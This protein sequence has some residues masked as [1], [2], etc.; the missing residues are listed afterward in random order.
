MIREN[1]DT[2]SVRATFPDSVSDLAC[3]S[4][5]GERSMH[6]YGNSP[7]TDTQPR[8]PSTQFR[9]RELLVFAIAHR[10]VERFCFVPEIGD[11]ADQQPLL[12]VPLRKIG[13]HA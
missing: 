9:N 13:T 11:S 1:W 12:D 3:R 10:I 6:P 8:A 2:F 4:G 5:G 7:A